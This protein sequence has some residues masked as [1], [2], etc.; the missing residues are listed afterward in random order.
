MVLTLI[1]LMTV[2][3]PVELQEVEL[4]F[5]SHIFEEGITYR[6]LLPTGYKQIV[7][8]PEERGLQIVLF[9]YPSG[10]TFYVT[11]DP[12]DHPNWQNIKKIQ[13]EWA[14]GAGIF[15]VDND[16]LAD[17][18]MHQEYN[19]PEKA[20][21]SGHNFR[22][23]WWRDFQTYEISYGYLRASKKWKNLFEKAMNSIIETPLSSVEPQKE[24]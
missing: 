9:Q 17:P 19:I 14:P 18:E 20:E 23:R 22:F 11:N 10:A 4:S 21:Y 1:V 24:I 6:L 2:L 15:L 7:L 5:H 16:Y 3:L 13:P 12:N 8:K